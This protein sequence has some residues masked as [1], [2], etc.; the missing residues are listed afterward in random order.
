MRGIERPARC[1]CEPISVPRPWHSRRAVLT[2]RG[3]GGTPK[4]SA[5]L[6]AVG[7][8]VG[9]PASS[10]PLSL[11]LGNAEIVGL[12]FPEGRRRAPLL[13]ALAG[14]DAP[15]A[16]SI[17]T[18]DR[19]RIV[20]ASTGETLS[21]ALTS[22]PDVVVLDID[23]RTTDRNTWARIASERALGTSFVVA[24]SSVDHAYRSDRVCFAGWDAAALSSAFSALARRMTSQVQEFLAVLG[25]YRRRGG[26]ELAADLLRLNHAGRDLLAE[27]RRLPRSSEYQRIL[28]R[29]AADLA[30]V[31]IDE[32]VL[33]SVIADAENRLGD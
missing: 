5:V 21:A 3:K 13:R 25:E 24:T 30:A 27:M 33:H 20:L 17:R 10:P 18:S 7:L 12:F 1:P 29:T 4:V 31:A 23:E 28:Q 11:Q 26:S 9:E 16:G 14:F 2:A 15:R 19:R 6:E 32:K 8:V 22:A